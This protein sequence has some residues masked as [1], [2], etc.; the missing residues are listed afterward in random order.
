[1][2][3]PAIAAQGSGPSGRHGRKNKRRGRPARPSIEFYPGTAPINPDRLS[4]D[5]QTAGEQ[6]RTR[7]ELWGRA[8]LNDGRSASRTLGD[9]ELAKAAANWAACGIAAGRPEFV[10]LVK[11]AIPSHAETPEELADLD[12]LIDGL[13]RERVAVLQP[14]DER[15]LE[16]EPWSTA[17]TEYALASFYF[18]PAKTGR[19]LRARKI[20]RED[21]LAELAVLLPS[22]RRDYQDEKAAG[23][24]RYTRALKRALAPVDPSTERA[25][26]KP[27]H[28]KRK[29]F[30]TKGNYE[31]TGT[32]RGRFISEPPSSE[33]MLKYELASAI[34]RFRTAENGHAAMTAEDRTELE[35]ILDVAS[36]RVATSL[37]RPH[38]WTPGGLMPP[39]WSRE[40][41]G[42]MVVVDNVS[43]LAADG[44]PG[45]T[46]VTV[47]RYEDVVRPL[48]EPP[49]QYG[50][51]ALEGIGDSQQAARDGVWAGS[52]LAE[53]L[54]AEA[55]E[56][57][58]YDHG[59]GG[60][61]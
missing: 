13:I 31:T 35:Y 14:P 25:P 34:H 55:E 11:A 40:D 1:M 17:K 33:A 7:L 39:G 59:V 20:K 41:T 28:P 45:R 53:L 8:N 47:Q 32:G 16:L 61:W 26:F 37:S 5:L 23:S 36:D 49:D 46:D 3:K 12:A 6:F 60:D 44:G 15:A 21:A 18:G 38:N 29:R 24:K 43:H 52:V 48:W 54:N 58:A 51:A 19:A 4:S 27:R 2:T 22:L 10:P 9:R 42:V 56:Q 50:F 30:R 57:A